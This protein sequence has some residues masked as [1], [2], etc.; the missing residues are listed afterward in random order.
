MSD[1]RDVVF[2]CNLYLQAILSPRGPAAAC[3]QK[4][5]AGE[6]RLYV[7][8]FVLSEIRELPYHRKLRRFRS[9]T[10]ERVERFVEELL[11][12]AI[13]VT[14]PPAVFDYVR[15]PDDARYVD[16]AIATDANLVVSNDKDLLDLM[17]DTNPD[18]ESLRKQH[19]A[20]QILTPPEFLDSLR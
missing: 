19:P 4:V 5:L 20:L 18:G 12:T 13:L 2:D 17:N 15:D 8:P 16:L 7:A 11:D 14:D 10:H 6:V 3:W 1:H 9:F